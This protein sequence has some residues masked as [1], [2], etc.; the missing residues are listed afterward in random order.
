MPQKI[1]LDQ[2][3]EGYEGLQTLETPIK[4]DEEGEE[5]SG[6]AKKEP[7]VFSFDFNSIE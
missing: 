2:G 5:D 4:S 1:H 6:V 7:E 3:K